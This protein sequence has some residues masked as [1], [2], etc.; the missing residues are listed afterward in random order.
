MPSARIRRAQETALA[1]PWFD[2]HEGTFRPGQQLTFA[3]GI[4]VLLSLNR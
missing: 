1:F 2:G 4:A 3:G